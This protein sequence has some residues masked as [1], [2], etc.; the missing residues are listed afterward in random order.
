[1]ESERRAYLLSKPPDWQVRLADLVKHGRDGE[2]SVRTG[3]DELRRFGYAK[4]AAIRGSAGRLNG[5][6]WTVYECP[7][8]ATDMAIFPTSA[9]TDPRES[10]RSG[11]TSLTNMDN[12]TNKDCFLPRLCKLFERDNLFLSPRETKAWTAVKSMITGADIRLVERFHRSRRNASMPPYPRQELATLLE[13]FGG[14]LDKAKRIFK[15][16]AHCFPS[17]AGIRNSDHEEASVSSGD[18]ISIAANCRRELNKLREKLKPM[19]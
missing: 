2:E 16:S 3:L 13:N 7:D 9:K 15:S 10:L 12:S 1:V 5:T 14:E 17:L 18:R 19:A 11:K 4:F 8:D 6:A